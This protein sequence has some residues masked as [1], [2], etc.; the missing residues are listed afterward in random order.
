M[1]VP[2]NSYR[3]FTWPT[4]A[5]AFVGLDNNLV[6]TNVILYCTV[7]ANTGCRPLVHQE[8][9][10]EAWNKTM[11]KKYYEICEVYILRDL[12]RI[13]SQSSK[14]CF[15]RSSAVKDYRIQTRQPSLLNPLL[16]RYATPHSDFNI[17]YEPRYKLF[18]F[19][20][21]NR[22]QYILMLKFSQ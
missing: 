15:A 13:G 22:E 9:A 17:S 3:L 4:H 18:C 11:M 12:F 8:L 10:F 2:F 14:A 7:Y 16:R 21:W 6:N 1:C 20:L 5:L 19:S